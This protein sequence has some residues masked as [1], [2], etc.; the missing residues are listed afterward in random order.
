MTAGVETSEGNVTELLVEIKIGP[1][2]LPSIQ[3]LWIKRAQI[4]IFEKRS[5]TFFPPLFFIADAGSGNP[6]S[7]IRDPGRIKIRITKNHP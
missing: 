5:N 7:G 3:V 2:G 1:L 6:S 4:F